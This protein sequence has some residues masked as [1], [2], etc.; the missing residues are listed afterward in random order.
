MWNSTPKERLTLVGN[1]VVGAFGHCSFLRKNDV[2][3]FQVSR[4]YSNVE[5]VESM[6]CLIG[7]A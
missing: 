4:I 7:K 3:K 6:L 2:G 1:I 5:I